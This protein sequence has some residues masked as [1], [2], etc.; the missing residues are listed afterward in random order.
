MSN[1][2]HGRQQHNRRSYRGEYRRDEYVYG[3]V[4]RAL[5][6]VKLDKPAPR[7]TSDSARRSKAKTAKMNIG[8]ILFLTVAILVSGGVCIQYLRMQ[9]EMTSQIRTISELEI[10]LNNLRAEND[11]TES[12]IK[13]AIDLEVIKSK[14]MTELGMQYAREDQIVSYRSND[15]DYVRQY[16]D[17]E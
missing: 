3:N 5:E 12:R 16:I 9:S 1:V 7:Q 6:P 8:W 10:T 2:R 14:A 11:D 4:A 17:V 15:D 13:G